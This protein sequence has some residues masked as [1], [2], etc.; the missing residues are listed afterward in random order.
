LVWLITGTSTGLGR[1]LVLAAL[2]RGDKIIATA[3]ARSLHFLAD[4]KE[5]SA[6]MLELDVTAPPDDLKKVADKAVAIYGRVDVLVNNAGYILVGA[7]EESTPEETFDQFNTD[8]FGALNVT[9]AFLPHMRARRTGTFV[10][11]GSIG[12][13]RAVPNAGLYS[14]TKW[15]LRR[16]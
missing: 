5:T 14:T 9:R 10:W 16:R 2:E 3:R 8:V 6:E 12:G 7:P 1:D 15:A 13:W 4:L 11:L